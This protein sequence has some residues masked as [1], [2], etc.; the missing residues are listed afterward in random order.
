MLQVANMNPISLAS[1]LDPKMVLSKNEQREIF[2]FDKLDEEAEQKLNEE[3]GN[4]PQ[5][6]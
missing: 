5:Q 3:Q 2:G 1:S 6:L 4:Q